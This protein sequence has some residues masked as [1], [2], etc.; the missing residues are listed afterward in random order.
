MSLR[1]LR[2]PPLD[3][4]LNSQPPNTSILDIKAAIHARTAIPV[5]KIRVLHKKKPVPDSRVL[6]ELA[7]ADEERLELGVMVIGGAAV[8][9]AAEEEVIPPVAQS[10][11]EV[12]SGERFWEDLKA[13]LVQRVRD[14]EVGG[15]AYE[16]FRRAWEER[17]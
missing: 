2:N 7:G 13:F 8:L 11:G 9:K 1:S 6:K 10:G 4:T 14:E 17:R 5:D 3:I 15:K 12:L 16:V